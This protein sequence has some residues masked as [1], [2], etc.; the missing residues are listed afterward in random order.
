MRSSLVLALLTA[1]TVALA[2]CSTSTAAS[3]A[4]TAAP[5]SP[6]SVASLA[7]SAVPIDSPS[8]AA[9]ASAEPPPSEIAAGPSASPTSIDPCSLLTQDE[10]SGAVGAK[11]GAGV[12]SRVD[13]ERVC[14]FKTGTTEVK[15]IVAPPAPDAATAAAYWDAE[16]G[17]VPA[18]VN[19]HDVAGFDRAAYGSGAQGGFS[20]S[21][22]FVIKGT[23]FFDFYC[24]LKACTEA[25]SVSAAQQI[26]SRLP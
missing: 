17:Q 15:V 1:L 25:N 8:T 11:L 6:I 3:T 2:A 21:A 9:S 23:T 18:G 20:V 7:A 19:I 24:G 26:V 14:T 5:A 13:Q 4:P 22:L 16:R 10:A 12:S